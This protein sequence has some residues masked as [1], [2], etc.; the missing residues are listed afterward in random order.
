MLGLG[1]RQRCETE[2]HV[3]QYLDK[4]TSQ[5]TQ[6]VVAEG[7]L[8]LGA[9]KQLG[10]ADHLLDHHCGGVGNLHHAVKLSLELGIVL[11]VECHTAH[12]ALVHGANDLDY[13]GI[14]HLAGCSNEFVTVG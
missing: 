9:D 12:V 1:L 11:D 14:T 13:D 5:T 6:H 4:D 7:L 3:L 10:A 8:V 2:L